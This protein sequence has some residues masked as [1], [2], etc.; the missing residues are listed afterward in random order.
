LPQRLDNIAAIATPPGQGGIGVV[1]VS[2]KDLSLITLALVGRVLAPRHATYSTFLDSEGQVIDRGI[3]IFFPG[4][5]SYT[6]EDVLELQAHGGT[7]VLQMLLR[8]CLS[9]GART[10]QPGEF[11]LRAFLNNKLDLIQAE[12]V[13]DLINAASEQAVRSANRS[14]E[15]DFSKAI[16][17]LVNELITLRMLVEASLDFPEEELDLS[18]L[19]RIENQLNSI[20]TKLEQIFKLA[21]Q[22]S[23]LR[24]GA[25]VVLVGQPNVGKSSLL[26][27]LAGEDVALV[28]EVAGT[29]RDAIRQEI[30]ISGVP[31]HLIDTAGL[32]ESGDIVE[33]MGM[34]RTKLAMQK[35]DAVI[36]L[37][38]VHNERPEEH[39]KIINSIPKHTPKIYVIN[40]IDLQEQKSRIEIHEGLSYIYLSAKTEAG[41]DL[42]RDTLLKLINWQGDTGVFMARERHL[43]ALENAFQYLHSAALRLS[44]LELLAEDLRL[45]QD[46]LSKITGKFSS[47]DLLGEIFSRF[48]IGK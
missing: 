8:R 30:S 13:G 31:I 43:Q 5:N 40:K 42:L 24:E 26:N 35:A 1:R 14:L 32:R 28:S 11:T 21:K 39:S 36:V 47:D 20:R 33:N 29:T 7:G 18:D 19:E 3:A 48:C 4:P 45:A 12:S 16:N 41:I 37:M 22:G 27:R 15:G 46:E 10:A 25:Q 23:L 44:S 17:F 38:E 34:E 6:G 9:V 2:G